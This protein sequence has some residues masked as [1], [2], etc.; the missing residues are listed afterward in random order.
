[1]TVSLCQHHNELKKMGVRFVS[2]LCCF[3]STIKCDHLILIRERTGAIRSSRGHIRV[4]DPFLGLV[5]FVSRKTLLV[6]MLNIL[7]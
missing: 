6:G 2:L 3:S 5:H 1:M 7:F 4:I